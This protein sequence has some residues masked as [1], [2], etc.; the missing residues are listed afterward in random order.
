[1][2]FPYFLKRFRKW[3]IDE[4]IKN[5]YTFSFEVL[6][7]TRNTFTMIKISVSSSTRNAVN[8]YD[9]EVIEKNFF[10]CLSIVIKNFYLATIQTISQVTWFIAFAMWTYELV[11]VRVYNWVHRMIITP[12]LSLLRIVCMNHL[13]IFFLRKSVDK[14]QSDKRCFK[15]GSEKKI[16]LE[17]TTKALKTKIKKKINKSVSDT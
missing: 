12:H 3:R 1:M 6:S 5:V 13:K 15:C 14:Q 11:K 7:K 2:G 8:K 4:N 10:F 9:R 17:M 16:A